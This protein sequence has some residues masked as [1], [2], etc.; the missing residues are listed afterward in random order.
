MLTA[1]KALRAEYE[2][3]AAQA[4]SCDDEEFIPGWHAPAR[5]RHFTVSKNAFAWAWQKGGS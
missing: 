2:R 3:I 1:A 4:S 5:P